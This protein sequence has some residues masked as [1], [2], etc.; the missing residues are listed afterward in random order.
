MKRKVQERPIYNIHTFPIDRDHNTPTMLHVQIIENE[1]KPTAE[2]VEQDGHKYEK[3]QMTQEMWAR[4]FPNEPYPTEF[5]D[6]KDTRIGRKGDITRW[7]QNT[8]VMKG[9]KAQ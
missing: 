5:K 6:Y 9:R 8:A 1:Q 2:T 7:N 3:Y 4:V